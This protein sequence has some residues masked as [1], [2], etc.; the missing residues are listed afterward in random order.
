MTEGHGTT[1]REKKAENF[2]PLNKR[3]PHTFDT[4]GIYLIGI[5]IFLFGIVLIFGID[6]L[7]GLFR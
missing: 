5:A 2:Q 7:F 3:K 4:M 1:I 6:K